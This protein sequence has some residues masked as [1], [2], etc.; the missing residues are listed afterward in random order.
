MNILVLNGSPHPDGNT[1]AM[2]QAFAE[3]AKEAGNGVTVLKIGT[4]KIAACQACEF[5]HTR[6]NGECVQQDDMQEVYPALKK[7]EMLVLASPVHYFGMSGQMQCAISRIYALK[8]PPKMKKVAL[9]LSS[10]SPGVYG[11]ATQQYRDAFVNFM[12][13][14]DMGIITANGAE[15]KSAAKLAECRHFGQNLK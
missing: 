7:A 2:A 4:K 14:Q 13:G 1:S 5:C 10:S 12:K 11:A 6:G 9:L 15:N 3:G 8:A